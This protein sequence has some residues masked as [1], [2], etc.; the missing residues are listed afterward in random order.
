MFWNRILGN[1]K[2]ILK[3]LISQVKRCLDL[4]NPTLTYIKRKVT[5]QIYTTQVLSPMD[6]ILFPVINCMIK[7]IQLK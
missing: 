3:S 7:L 1:R 6:T 4:E 2:D 5:K